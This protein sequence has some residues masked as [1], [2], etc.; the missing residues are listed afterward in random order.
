MHDA[1]EVHHIDELAQA[2]CRCLVQVL[3]LA[4]LE[5]PTHLAL[6]GPLH[7]RRRQAH[8]S[9]LQHPVEGRLV[10]RE[11]V[12]AETELRGEREHA[13]RGDL[14][15]LLVRA[16]HE[17]LQIFE[18]QLAVVFGIPTPHDLPH[19]LAVI[20][21]LL[22]HHPAEERPAN[23]D[24]DAARVAGVELAE[25]LPQPLPA[26]C[27]LLGTDAVHERDELGEVHR[28]VAVLVGLAEQGLDLPALLVVLVG[29]EAEVLEHQFR[30]LVR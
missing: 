1:Q 10:V 27:P 28:A 9:D 15:Q 2:A 7:L 19:Q 3:E 25:D 21:G 14:V 23:L 12:G 8:A 22:P 30:L 13:L 24:A 18:V 11:D 6:D 17:L 26:V 4:A 5:R 16:L 20:L 29:L